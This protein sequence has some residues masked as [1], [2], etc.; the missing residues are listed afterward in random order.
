MFHYSTVFPERLT[1]YDDDVLVD[2]IVLLLTNTFSHQ[3]LQLKCAIT[4]LKE[5][6][7]CDDDYILNE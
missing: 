1:F 7:V 2:D 4:F 5:Y 6:V 3:P